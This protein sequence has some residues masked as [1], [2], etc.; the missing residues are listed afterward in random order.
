MTWRVKTPKGRHFYRECKPK[1]LR[2]CVEIVEFSMES[3]GPYISV[4]AASLMNTRAVCIW[5]PLDKVSGLLW[6]LGIHKIN[7]SRLTSI[8][9]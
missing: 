8:V 1:W 4:R 9:S 5:E 3:P 7:P 2:S 6:A